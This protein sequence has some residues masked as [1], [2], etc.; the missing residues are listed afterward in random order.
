MML[1]K[2]LETFENY[3]LLAAHVPHR[4]VNSCYKFNGDASQ[5]QEVLDVY[6]L[7]SSTHY[8]EA[9]KMLTRYMLHDC[10]SMYLT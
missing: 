8:R 1:R 10:I 7:A 3:G 9:F 2:F 5:T 4:I 6:N